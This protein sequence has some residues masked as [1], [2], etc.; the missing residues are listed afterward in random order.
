MRIALCN[1]QEKANN[2]SP[3]TR[4]MQILEKLLLDHEKDL[5]LDIF[6]Y[7]MHNKEELDKTQIKDYDKIILVYATKY[8][9]FEWIEKLLKRNKNSEILWIT[10]E[11][12][13][14]LNSSLR[15]CIKE[16]N[17][18]VIAN[19]QKNDTNYPWDSLDLNVLCYQEDAVINLNQ[20]KY[21]NLIYW[22][23]FREG[24]KRYFTKYLYSPEAFFSCSKR[25][26]V[27]FRELGLKCKFIDKLCWEPEKETLRLF[28]YAL[29]IEDTHTHK[30]FNHLANRFYESVYCDTVLFFDKNCLGSI[31]KSGFP[32]EDDFIV[33]SYKEIKNKIDHDRYLELLEKQRKLKPLIV[34]HKKKVEKELVNLI[35]RN[36]NEKA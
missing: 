26:I 33:S 16:E 8:S 12:N 24:R 19:F 13:L 6:Y 25:K 11:Y 23:T 21:D 18:R 3:H 7:A 31:K 35:E 36:R 9:Y 27:T 10:N 4:V 20:K 15:K 14:M 28:K 29:Y 2:F 34:E 5:E 30:V 1:P 22:G 17:F 32:I